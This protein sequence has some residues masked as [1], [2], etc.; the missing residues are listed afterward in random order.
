MQIRIL[1]Q[2]DVIRILPMEQA[3]DRMRVAFGELSAGR[4]VMPMRTRVDTDHGDMHLMPACLENSGLTVKMVL[5]YPG[6]A[7]RGLPLIQGTLMVFDPVTGTPRALMN[8]GAL[9]AI[10]TGAAGGL[11][12]DLLARTDS[13][14]LG[15][16]GA[17]VQ[18]RMQVRAA[19][20]VRDIRQVIVYDTCRSSVESF[21]R[22]LD[23]G[24]RDVEVIVADE[25]EQ[26][27]RSSDIVITATTSQTPTFE[28]RSLRAGT[29]VNAIG[30]YRPERREVDEHTVRCAYVVADSR[31]ACA[32]EAGDLIIP[33]RQP[34]A[35]LGEIVN[36]TAPARR[37]DQQITLFKSV[38]LAV[39][40]AA[41]A[42]WILDQAERQD[43]GTLVDL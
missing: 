33:G 20:A 8:C 10:R 3:I 5:T 15:L 26:T 32:E 23:G 19:M 27:V 40:D 25:P 6:N 9:T 30:S 17:G 34:D 2:D 7:Q 22:R 43:A 36:G 13:H 21:H 31:R 37:D 1:T 42:T 16:I 28:G 12:I 35:E 4:A 41:T 14:V 29:H 38:G 39:Q 11:A 18:G 24:T